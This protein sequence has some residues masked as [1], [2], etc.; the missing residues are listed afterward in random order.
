M[1]DSAFS[2]TVMY[3]IIFMLLSGTE[4]SKNENFLFYLNNYISAVC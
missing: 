4:H 1:L 3:G 2:E